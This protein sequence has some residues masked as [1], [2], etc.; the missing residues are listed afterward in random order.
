MLYCNVSIHNSGALEQAPRS[1]AHEDQLVRRFITVLFDICVSVST[2]QEGWMYFNRYRHAR[3]SVQRSNQQDE[4]R[5]ADP[6]SHSMGSREFG[7]T[8]K[9]E[10]V[11]QKVTSARPGKRISPAS[12]MSRLICRSLCLLTASF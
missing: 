10:A 4:S 7:E 8:D 5:V 9:M 2:N 6:S 3:L 1:S 12:T 11:H